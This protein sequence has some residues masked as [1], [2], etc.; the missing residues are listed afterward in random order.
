MILTRVLVAST[1]ST[2]GGLFGLF[3]CPLYC[4]RV[5]ALHPVQDGL[6]IRDCYY[7]VT[8]NTTTCIDMNGDIGEEEER[9]YLLKA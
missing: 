7:F 9:D 1:A 2:A 3:L 6:R 8:I 4:V 5:C